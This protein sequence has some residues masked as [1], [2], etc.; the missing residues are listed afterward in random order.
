MRNYNPKIADEKRVSLG[1][2]FPTVFCFLLVGLFLIPQLSSGQTNSEIDLETVERDTIATMIKAL[3]D[4]I[5]IY[6]FQEQMVG[7]TS[8]SAFA[9]FLSNLSDEDK[10]K[11]IQA[12][13]A[14]L[15]A[16]ERYIISDLKRR[17][18][19]VQEQR[20]KIQA[21]IDEQLLNQIQ[22]FERFLASDPK[23]IELVNNIRFKL[24]ELYYE[25]SDRRYSE[26]MEKWRIESERAEAGLI[27]VMP[28]RPERDLG[29][30]I[31]M[32]ESVV[33]SSK[34]PKLLPYS[35]YSLGWSYYTYDSLTLAALS[36]F[37]RL[38]V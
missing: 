2:R 8:D 6:K 5:A 31:K 20:K 3:E 14:F 13:I 27:P 32:Y 12:R 9:N 35:L 22:A 30:S 16:K 4:T 29:K 33:Q 7:I 23:E 15:E 10:A 36:K 11:A 34:D 25:E 28:K 1:F 17:R 24:A 21:E 19:I 38:S 18:A 37:F 26:A